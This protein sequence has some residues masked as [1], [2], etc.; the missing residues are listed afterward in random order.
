MTGLWKT[1]PNRWHPEENPTPKRSTQR[2]TRGTENKRRDHHKPRPKPKSSHFPGAFFGFGP[3]MQQEPEPSQSPN[4]S[5]NWSP[6][7]SLPKRRCGLLVRE[8][9]HPLK[10]HL[11]SQRT[12]KSVPCHRSSA[13]V[14]GL[15]S[16]EVR[17]LLP[18][19]T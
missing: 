9:V 15:L 19:D 12:N 7:Q 10:V 3:E 14:H 1:V 8:N 4:Q 6:N 17:L 16:P 18:D 11:L 13:T 2:R 5:C